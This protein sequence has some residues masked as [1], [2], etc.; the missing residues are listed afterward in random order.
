MKIFHEIISD[1]VTRHSIKQPF[2]FPLIL[3]KD[4]PI[5]LGSYSN[6]YQ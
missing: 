4:A 1:L 3:D 2:P 6:F 5:S